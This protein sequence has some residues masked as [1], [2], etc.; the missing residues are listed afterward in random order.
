MPEL[1]ICEGAQ[2][3]VLPA[4][5]SWRRGARRLLPLPSKKFLGCSG[6]QMAVA[7]A[8]RPAE[9]FNHWGASLQTNVTQN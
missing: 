6:G 1:V 8:L 9:N 3:R 7:V 4:H 5:S 2:E